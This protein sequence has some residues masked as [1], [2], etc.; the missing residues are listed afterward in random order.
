MISQ[1]L[2][3]MPINVIRNNSQSFH[4]VGSVVVEVKAILSVFGFTGPIALSVGPHN[5]SF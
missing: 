3:Q 5:P 2:S 4:S 1:S